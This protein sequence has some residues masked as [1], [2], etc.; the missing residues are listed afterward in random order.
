[1]DSNGNTYTTETY[2]GKRIQ[3]FTYM[4]MNNVTV[5]DFGAAWPADRKRSQ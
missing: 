3:K 2:E 1:M 4:G 5:T